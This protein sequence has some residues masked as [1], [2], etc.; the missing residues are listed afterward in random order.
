[1]TVF[2]AHD[3]DGRVTQSNKLFDPT[4]YADMLR[5]RQMTFVE[6]DGPGPINLEA[7][8][9]RNGELTAREAMPVT[10]SATSI[11][12][13]GK[14]VAI[15]SGVPRGARVTI[16]TGGLPPIWNGIADGKPFD[17]PIP[18]PCIY[19]VTVDLWPFRTWSTEVTAS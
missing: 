11:K 7:H 17:L 2:T 13:G 9:V 16:S 3:P 5:E 6:H 18:V 14:E 8:W 15:F 1:M 10:V 12:A 4:G 19:V